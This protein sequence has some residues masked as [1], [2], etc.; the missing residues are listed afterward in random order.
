[1]TY[2][3]CKEK[4]SN[5]QLKTCFN[6]LRRQKLEFL[7]QYRFSSIFKSYLHSF[8]KEVEASKWKNSNEYTSAIVFNLIGDDSQTFGLRC[9]PFRA[10]QFLLRVLWSMLIAKMRCFEIQFQRIAVKITAIGIRTHAPTD[11]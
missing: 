1:M 2:F 5:R 11:K 9:Q 3:W 6:L 10:L 8:Q 7:V 4:Q